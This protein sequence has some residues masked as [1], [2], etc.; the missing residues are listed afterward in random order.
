MASVFG[1]VLHLSVFG[2]SHSPAIG[3]SLDG[4][5]AGIPVNVEE[6]NAFMARRAPGRSDTA[7]TRKEGDVPEFIAGITDGHTNGAPIA[8]IIRVCSS[9]ALPTKGRPVRSSSYP[10]PSPM[11]INRG[12]GFPS[13]KTIL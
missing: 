2:Q 1:N 5:P 13:P 3:C 11:N 6:L 4:I 7:T 12:W 10:G 8:A 9:P